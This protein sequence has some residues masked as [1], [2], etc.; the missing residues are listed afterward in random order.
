MKFLESIPTTATKTKNAGNDTKGF[1]LFVISKIL[2]VFPFDQTYGYDTSWFSFSCALH[3]L[4]CASWIGVIILLILTDYPGSPGKYL[5]KALHALSQVL[6]FS[7]IISH[8]VIV[9]QNPLFVGKL[10]AFTAVYEHQVFGKAISVGALLVAGRSVP[11]AVFRLLNANYKKMTE[12]ILHWFS[13]M[14]RL[15]VIFQFCTFLVILRRKLESH[16]KEMNQYKINTSAHFNMVEFMKKL[17]RIFGCQLLSTFCQI[18]IGTVANSYWF[19]NSIVTPSEW[20]L[21]QIL[22]SL[23]NLTA[24]IYVVFEMYVIVR[25]CSDALYQV[26]LFNVELFRLMRGSKQ[27]CENEKLYLYA[28]MKNSVTFTACG[29]FNLGYPLVTSIIAAAA[30]YLVILLQFS[31]ASHKQF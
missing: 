14:V 7:C 17:N 31:T 21:R 27:L 23:S 16:I 2:G 24:V 22:F 30:T 13:S 25:T 1:N 10:A 8:L 18:F 28:T 4:S 9:K 29:F 6:N 12:E 15:M 26:E 3:L 19:I 11:I 20:T 5:N